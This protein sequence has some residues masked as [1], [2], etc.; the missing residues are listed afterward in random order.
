MIRMYGNWM[1]SVNSRIICS[2]LNLILRNIKRNDN[3]STLKIWEN[4]KTSYWIQIFKDQQHLRSS[5]F[6]RLDVESFDAERSFVAGIALH[7]C[8]V[9]FQIYKLVFVFS[10][11]ELH[12]LQ[13]WIHLFLWHRQNKL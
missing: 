4:I 8:Y 12:Y 13:G 6:F 11:R 1:Q 3:Y 10:T 2:Q 5:C 7:W 9:L